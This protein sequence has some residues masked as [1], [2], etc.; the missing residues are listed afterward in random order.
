MTYIWE[1]PDWP[2]YSYDLERLLVL[3]GEV[4]H[5]QGHL[6]G[7]MSSLGLAQREQTELRMMTEEV[8]TSSAIEG[9]LLDPGGVRSSLARRLGLPEAGVS[10]PDRATDGVVAM[11]LDAT[12]HYDQPLT[13][14]RLF[15]WHA[16][17]FPT[18]YADTRKIEVARWRTDSRGPMQVVSGAV[19]KWRVHYEAP[20]AA[21]VAAEMQRFMD[22]FNQPPAGL[23]VLIRAAL[24]HL[25]FV[26]IHPLDDGN[27]R[28][29]RA[30]ADAALAGADGVRQR[31]YS[32]SSRIRA[33]RAAYYAIL[34][35]TQHGPLDVT[36]WIEWFLHCLD[37]AIENAQSAT[38]SVLA[39]AEFW[40]RWDGAEL[41]AR[42]RK[43]LNRL[44][45]G[46]DG[47]LTNRKWRGIA[48]CSEATAYR[49][50][51]ELVKAGVL[52]KLGGHRDASYRLQTTGAETLP[53]PDRPLTWKSVPSLRTIF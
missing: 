2:K 42:Q 19:G 13:A 23:D 33:E 1:R 31:F 17:L 7:R 4:R 41:N 36:A 11:M 38:E 40:R 3:L 5:K 12:Q 48:H 32:M 53:A 27:G 16:A 24:A 34:E 45:D 46:F 28:I 52:A 50:L 49:D 37:R 22:W 6:L 44:L 20:P 51:D 10:V 15:G 47:D 8:L 35:R 29:A 9:E 18:G 26:T 43:V 39:K 21:R 30:I 14:E 25:W